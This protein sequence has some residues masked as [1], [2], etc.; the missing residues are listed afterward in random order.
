[1]TKAP[2]RLGL[3]VLTLLAAVLSGC[4]GAT[5]DADADAGSTADVAS[6]A[7]A[8]VAPS[9][10]ASGAAA[11]GRPQL[12]L[13]MTD[14][15]TNRLW[16]TYNICLRDNGVKENKVRMEA[17]AAEGSNVISLDQSGEP[18]A[19]YVACANKLPLQP[20]ELDEERNPNYVSQW[21][22][23]VQCLRGRGM[24]IH[25]LPDGSGWTYDDG[26]ADPTGGLDA[27]AMEKAEKECTMEAFG[28]K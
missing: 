5:S 9:A 10:S 13:D 4:G 8:S 21:N 23:Y 19:A 3:V 17:A 27:P 14:D 12:R 25:A 7:T 11:T 15:E 26:V 22:D 1:M 28:G 20:P 16:N 2:Q 18:K 6:L 24:K